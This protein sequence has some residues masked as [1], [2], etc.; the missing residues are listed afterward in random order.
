MS[1]AP[2]VRVALDW[3]G[4]AHWNPY[5]ATTGRNPDLFKLKKGQWPPTGAGTLPYLGHCRH[6]R[7]NFIRT[8][9]F[10]LS[11]SI[12][13]SIILAHENMNTSGG[14]HLETGFLLEEHN[15]IR[16]SEEEVA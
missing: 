9:F 16:S 15:E 10:L 6:R 13:H 14:I 8:Q 7:S 11:F 4:M 5:L 3:P 1:S 12:H 2:H